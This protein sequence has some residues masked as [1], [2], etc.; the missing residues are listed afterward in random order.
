MQITLGQF[1]DYAKIEEP[2]QEDMVRILLSKS[3]AQVDKMK[4][5]EFNKHV[6]EITKQI[7]KEPIFIDKFKIGGVEFGFIPNLDEICYGEN[8]DLTNY[9]NDWQTMHLAMAVSF[10][11]ITLKKGGKYLI[12][13]YGGTGKTGLLMKDCPLNVVQGM[14]VFFYN[15]I[16]D[17][18]SCIPKFIATEVANPVALAASG[19]D[20]KK[21]TRLAKAILR[22]LTV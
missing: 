1:Q 4:V 20:T 2:T 9:I 7:E 14:N 13:E 12:E 8:R 6:N 11:P 19:V 10:R 18:L 22:N 15:L 17:L 3:K 21:F 5:D 16:N